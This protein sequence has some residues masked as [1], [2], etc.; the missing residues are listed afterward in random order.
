MGFI[1]SI[2]DPKTFL[3]SEEKKEK[4]LPPLPQLE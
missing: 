3:R 1:L 4:V 2:E